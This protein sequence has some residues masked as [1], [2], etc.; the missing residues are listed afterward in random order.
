M[1]LILDFFCPVWDPVENKFQQ[2]AG[3]DELEPRLTERTVLRGR[4]APEKAESRT[5]TATRESKYI[6]PAARDCPGGVAAIY[7]RRAGGQA[8]IKLF[9]SSLGDRAEWQGGG[10]AWKWTWW[11]RSLKLG[12]R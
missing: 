9:P 7:E 11:I 12:A 6:Q 10:C 1:T 3:S 5:W 8:I 4:S 2:S